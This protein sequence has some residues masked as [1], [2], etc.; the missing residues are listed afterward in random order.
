MMRRHEDIFM[1]NT[2]KDVTKCS[3]NIREIIYDQLYGKT[4]SINRIEQ[5]ER[6]LQK[7]E[8]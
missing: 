2:I 6:E 1:W 8:R 5:L 4:W 7:G 3:D